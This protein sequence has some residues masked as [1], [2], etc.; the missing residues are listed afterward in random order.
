MEGL[1][2][3][4]VRRLVPVSPFVDHVLHVFLLGAKQQV[5]WMHTWWIVTE[6]HN[7]LVRWQIAKEVLVEK[8]MRMNVLA[9][10]FLCR[11][12]ELSVPLWGA[13]ASPY[14]AVATGVNVFPETVDGWSSVAESATDSGAPTLNAVGGLEHN[15]TLPADSR[16][17]VNHRQLGAFARA[18]LGW[19]TAVHCQAWVKSDPTLRAGKSRAFRDT[20]GRLSLHDNLRC[21]CAALRV[22]ATTPEHLHVYYTRL[23][24]VIH[25]ETT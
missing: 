14:P 22:A 7:N 4:R 16:F 11:N 19:L 8:A 10:A 21:C 3:L 1:L 6:V 17:D 12:P 2:A 5:V 9:F 13:V 23:S 24:N 20:W 18:V 15:A 25:E